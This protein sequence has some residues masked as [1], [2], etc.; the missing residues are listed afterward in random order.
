MEYE[1]FECDCNTAFCQYEPPV[2]LYSFTTGE[3][4]SEK[5][6]RWMNDAQVTRTLGRFD[7]LMPVSQQKLVEYYRSLNPNNTIFLAIYYSDK[8]SC[9]KKEQQ[10]F[11]GTLKIYDI[12]LLAQRASIGVMVGNKSDWNKNIAST[13]IRIAC[14]YIFDV[15]GFRKITAGYISKNTGM[16]KAFLKNGFQVEATLKE[17]LFFEG[18]FVDHVFVCK[19]RGK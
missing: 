16:E 4:Y 15:L 14:R 17:H 13:A 9:P 18:N 3:L 7:Y 12:E 11:V 5:Y 10:E 8:H 1:S 6:L 2:F 19:F